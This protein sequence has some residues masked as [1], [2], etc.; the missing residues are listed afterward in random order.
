MMKNTP[1]CLV[2]RTA[3]FAVI[4]V[5]L[6]AAL[7]ATTLR[8]QRPTVAGPTAGVAAG[9]PLTTAAA[10]EPTPRVGFASPPVQTNRAAKRKAARHHEHQQH[11]SE[12]SHGEQY[13]AHIAQLPSK[14]PALAFFTT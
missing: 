5:G 11:K 13:V 14:M 6:T 7:T 10:F 12:M 4:L 1:R 8:A 9:H 3:R 2:G